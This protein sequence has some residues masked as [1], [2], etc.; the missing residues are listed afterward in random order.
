MNLRNED[1]EKYPAEGIL[2]VDGSGVI[3]YIDHG[4]ARMLKVSPS[5]ALGYRLPEV[6]PGT[7]LLEIYTLR[8]TLTHEQLFENKKVRVTYLPVAQQSSEGFSTSK[9]FENQES[10]TKDPQCLRMPGGNHLDSKIAGV[11]V[12]FQ[13]VSST[14]ASAQEIETHKLLINLYEKIFADLPLGIA[15]VNRQGRIVMI[16]KE[17]CQLLGLKE[18][19]ALGLSINKVVPFTKLNEVMRS[20][21][22]YLDSG[23]KHKE[24]LFFLSETPVKSCDEVLGGLSKL[25]LKE[26]LEGQDLKDLLERFQLLE[27]KLMFYKEELKEL[28]RLRSPLEEIVGEAP[29]IKKLKQLAQR[30]AMGDANILITG[31]SGTGKGLFAQAIHNISYRNGEPFIKINCAAIPENLLESEL[32][33]YEEGAFT[34][35][36]RGGKLGKFDLANGGTI[37][38]DEIG[39]MPLAM[40]A[41]I[42][43]VLQEKTFERVGGSKTLTVNVRVIAATNRDLQQLIDEGQFRLDLYYR[44]A[45]I[46]LYIQPLRERQEDIFLLTREIINKLNLKYGCNV[47][48]VALEVEQSLCS[49]SWPGNVRELENI[50]EYAFNFLEPE[51]NLIRLEHLPGMFVEKNIRGGKSGSPKLASVLLEE[52]VAKAE[53]EAI[54]EALKLSKGNKQEAAKLLGIHLSGLYQKLKK[55]SIKES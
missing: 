35:A 32:F 45:V 3:T 49:H 37:F 38:L 18:K 17:Y 13:R 51:E 7:R 20:G 54:L 27:S 52:A 50:L 53:V 10:K 41:K 40:Q 12:F 1:V 46:N 39:D 43:R 19:D 26:K 16:N 34:G 28:R 24:R 4:A 23:V 5:Q 21:E 15:V 8:K 55:Y 30:V 47:E 48:G 11:A 22:H 42:L 29:Q 33:G 2:F 44:L 9:C 25:F 14:E 6:Y 31:E 36:V